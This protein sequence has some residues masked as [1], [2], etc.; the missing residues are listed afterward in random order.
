VSEP[1]ASPGASR[2]AT[3]SWLD[4]RLVLGVLLVLVSVVVGAR[5]LSAA[6]RSTLVWAASKDLSAGSQL[7]AGDL[8]PVRVRLFD[9]LDARYVPADQSPTGLL[10]ERGLEGGELLPRQGLLSPQEEVDLRLVTVPVEG[11]RFPLGLAADQQVDVWLTPASAVERAEQASR[12]TGSG[13]ATGPAVPSGPAVPAAPGGAAVPADPADPTAATDPTAPGG[14]TAPTDPT[15]VGGPTAGDLQLTG[16]QPVLLKVLVDAV[17]D[18]ASGFGGS[19]PTVPVTL[20]VRPE[21]VERLVSALSLGRIDLV[22]VPK[23][24][25]RTSVELDAAAD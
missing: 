7:S 8:E 11:S 4:T 24:A 1:P 16:A 22:R 23:S 18:S 9:G 14:R 15:A 3:P 21:D 2:L 20:S 19:S 12:P 13:G 6:D 5:V 10:L 17:Q 25:E